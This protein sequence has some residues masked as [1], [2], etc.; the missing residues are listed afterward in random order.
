VAADAN[1]NTGVAIYDTYDQGGWLEVGGTSASSPIIASVFALAGVPTVG[2]FPNS[3]PYADPGALY[4]ITKGADG[5]CP[6]HPFLCHAE[7]GYDGP[8]GLGTP[9]ATAAFAS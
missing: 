7:V 2:S 3:Y 8:T 6:K 5:S 9:D 1:P 4:D